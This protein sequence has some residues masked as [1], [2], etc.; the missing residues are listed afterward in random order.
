MAVGF[1]D[2]RHRTI[3]HSHLLVALSGS[4]RMQDLRHVVI[5]AVS[6][7]LTGCGYRCVIIVRKAEL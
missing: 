1:L 4:L 5:Q 2:F 3:A 6:G 7:F